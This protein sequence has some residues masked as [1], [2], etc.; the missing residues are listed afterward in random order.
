[1]PRFGRRQILKA[2]AVVGSGLAIGIGWSRYGRHHP[3]VARAD[4]LATVAVPGEDNAWIRIAPD[5]MISIAIS[6]SE[7]G[8]GVETALA[9]IVAEELEAD[10]ARIDTRW[11]PSDPVFGG[12]HTA[13]SSSIRELWLPLREVAASARTMLI[14][15][16]AQLWQVPAD[17]C[18]ARQSRIYHP[19]SRRQLSYG[20]VADLAATLS[21]PRRPTLKDPSEFTLI[22]RRIPRLDSQA[23]TDGSALFGWDVQV[24]GMLVA[25]VKRCPVKGGRVADYD[26]TNAE[27]VS[28]VHAV[29]VV[30]EPYEAPGKFRP[31][32]PYGLAV[33]ANEYWSSKLGQ[34]ALQVSWDYGPNAA[35]DSAAITRMLASWAANDDAIPIVDRGNIRNIVGK[36][37]KEVSAVYQVP[38]LAHATMSPMCCTADVRDDGC[39]VWAPTQSPELA[40]RMVVR[41]TGLPRESIRIHKT[42]LGGGFGRRQR[43]DYVGEAVQISRSIDRP[44]KVLWS[45]EDDFQHDYFRPMSYDVLNG[46]LGDDGFPIGWRHRISSTENTVLSSKGADEVPYLIPHK[47]VD[48]ARNPIEYPIRVSTWRGVAHSQNAFAVESFVDELAH[49]GGHDPYAFRQ[50]LLRDAPRHLAVLDLAASRA[51]WGEAPREGVYRGI[52]IH[53]NAG[54]IAAE[55]AELSVSE[56]FEVE[57]HRVT[58]AIDCGL[59]INPDGVEAQVEGA[60]VD[61]L[62]TALVSEITIRNGRVQ[63]SNFHDYPLLRMNQIPQIEVYIVPHES[64]EQISGAGEVG[65]PPLAP[66]VANAVFAATGQRVRKLPIRLSGH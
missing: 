14:A 54:S 59:V 64:P 65:L 28:G 20:E 39:D 49:A 19:D 17:E 12:Q 15:A 11:A 51:G 41:H 21:I 26:A 43:Q 53:E 55:V 38:Y 32:Q 4:P 40:I 37:S 66:A 50:N 48:L 6:R 46:W 34:K 27:S 63:Q 5:N 3:G 16:A 45:R 18:Q 22:G 29:V 35:Y 33:V 60:I 56:Q 62:T 42:Y 30:R 8:Q 9:M 24:P 13:A 47:F 31:V 58:C 1:M 25:T 57:V 10:W 7:M 2:T 36:G 52:A 61:G 44:V 23:K